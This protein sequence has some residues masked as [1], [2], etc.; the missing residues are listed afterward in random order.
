[1]GVPSSRIVHGRDAHSP[2]YSSNDSAQSWEH[3]RGNTE[4]SNNYNNFSHVQR[5]LCVCLRVPKRIETRIEHKNVCS[6]KWYMMGVVV[7][8]GQCAAQR[9]VLAPDKLSREGSARPL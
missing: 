9:N 6:I 3:G 4:A 8:M 7:C 1:M 2:G 5:A